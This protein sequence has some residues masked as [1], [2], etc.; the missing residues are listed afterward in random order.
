MNGVKLIN[1]TRQAEVNLS[2]D[3]GVSTAI[4]GIFDRHFTILSNWLTIS[5][6]QDCYDHFVWQ[7]REPEEQ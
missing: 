5:I 1:I 6:Q 3:C 2:I 7:R 4:A